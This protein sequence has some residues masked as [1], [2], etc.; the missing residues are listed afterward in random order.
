M[1]LSKIDSDN[2]LHID[3]FGTPLRLDRDS[4]L[5]GKQHGGGV[6]LYVNTRWVSTVAER[7]K[8]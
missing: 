3:G 2:M 4:E 7:E 6:C 1:W 5:T 8:L